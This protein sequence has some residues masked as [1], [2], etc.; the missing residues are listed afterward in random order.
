MGGWRSREVQTKGIREKAE[1]WR[2]GKEVG[3]ER[4]ESACARE[5]GE[6]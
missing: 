2:R 5:A 1:G 6:V 4:C 3:G